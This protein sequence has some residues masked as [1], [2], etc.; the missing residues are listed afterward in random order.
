MKCISFFF[1]DE[2]MIES[3]NRNCYRLLKKNSIPTEGKT[4]IFS[5]HL[6]TINSLFINFMAFVKNPDFN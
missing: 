5:R 1:V 6:M 3:L 2:Y 4:D